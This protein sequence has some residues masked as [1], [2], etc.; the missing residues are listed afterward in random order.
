LTFWAT[1]W[2]KSEEYGFL[3]ELPAQIIQQKLKDLDKAF[4]DA[5]DKQQKNK[6]IPRFKCKGKSSVDSIRYPQG[7]KID[8]SNN[9]L[10]LPKIGW[11]NYRNSRKVVGIPKNVTVS[12]KG[13][14]WH[15]SIQVEYKANL[16]IHKSSSIVGIDMGVKHFATLSNG[17]VYE[18]LNSFKKNSEKLATLQRQ[19]SQLKNKTRFSHK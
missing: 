19:L 1:L 8:Q 4:R 15:V 7:F 2:K 17:K 9:R 13:N 11:V 14:Y 6:R 5:F 12:R 18:P 16:L 3:K 10:F